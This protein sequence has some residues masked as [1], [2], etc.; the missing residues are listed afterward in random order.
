M[1]DDIYFSVDKILSNGAVVGR[2]G[3]VD[4]PVGTVFG[5][6]RKLKLFRDGVGFWQPPK[7]ILERVSLRLEKVEWFR[8]FIDAIPGG[9]GAG[10]HLSGDGFLA[11]AR[12]LAERGESEYV[13]LHVSP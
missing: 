11:L 4:I 12:A 1:R 2:N 8:R 9:H 3:Y 6:V 5:S 10:L 13:S 7:C